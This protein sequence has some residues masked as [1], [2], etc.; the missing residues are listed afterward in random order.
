MEI[1]A[2]FA[3]RS[4]PERGRGKAKT[5]ASG[6]GFA[7]L[8][9]SGAEIPLPPRARG[10]EPAGTCRGQGPGRGKVRRDPIHQLSVALH[11]PPPRFIKFRPHLS[12]YRAGRQG[13]E[14]ASRISERGGAGP[15]LCCSG[16]PSHGAPHTAAR[17]RT[18]SSSWTGCPPMHCNVFRP[19]LYIPTRARWHRAGRP[20]LLAALLC[21]ANPETAAARV[22]RAG[23]LGR[24]SGFVYIPRAGGRMVRTVHL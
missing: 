10:A 14:A 17:T 5:A 18:R 20:N 16:R 15:S 19:S 3:P 13:S 1:A 11:V 9:V 23:P 2:K 24:K 7:A 4:E 22:A 8:R 12:A 6:V 21:S